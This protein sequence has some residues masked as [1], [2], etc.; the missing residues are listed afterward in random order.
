MQCRVILSGL[1]S[2]MWTSEH[3]IAMET[4]VVDTL[5]QILLIYI[6]EQNGLTTCFSSP[7]FEVKELAYFA[8]EE[9]A[10]ISTNNFIDVVQF[11]TVHG[12]YVDGLLRGMHDLYAPTFF[13][14]Q[15]WPDSIL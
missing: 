15:S 7:T 6:D 13:E 12:S 14:N 10:K 9:N 2:E 5:K 1:T 3:R 11:G 4:F 8:R